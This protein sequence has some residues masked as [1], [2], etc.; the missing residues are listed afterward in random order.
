MTVFP[1]CFREEQAGNDSRFIAFGVADELF[2][3]AF[4]GLSPDQH[5]NMLGYAAGPDQVRVRNYL[6]TT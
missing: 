5:T 1:P 6:F 2:V 4:T 3:Y